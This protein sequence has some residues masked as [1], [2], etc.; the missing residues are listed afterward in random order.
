[1]TQ[2]K[3]KAEQDKLAK[4]RRITWVAAMASGI[5][6]ITAKSIKLQI[7]GYALF[8]VGSAGYYGLFGADMAYDHLIDSLPKEETT[9]K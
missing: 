4:I 7:V 5:A 2:K 3:A 1:M 9:T 8:T 6:A